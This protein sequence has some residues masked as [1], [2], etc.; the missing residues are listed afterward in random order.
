MCEKS[1]NLI[2]HYDADSK[3]EWV[4]ETTAVKANRNCE[5]ITKKLSK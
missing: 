3:E 2:E 5:E 1:T 4:S